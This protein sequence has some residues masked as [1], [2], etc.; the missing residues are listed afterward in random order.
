[1]LRAFA[2]SVDTKNVFLGHYPC[3]LLISKSVIPDSGNWVFKLHDIS[4]IS[5]TK[6]TYARYYLFIVMNDRKSFQLMINQALPGLVLFET[7]LFSTLLLMM[8]TGTTGSDNIR[9]VFVQ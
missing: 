7:P 5:H 8:Y 9:P 2:R 3:T 1:M 6:T 4:K